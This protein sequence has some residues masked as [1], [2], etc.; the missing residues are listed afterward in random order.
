MK[1]LW[2]GIGIIVIAV[3]TIV[4][5]TYTRKES[6]VIKIGVILP[7]TGP[8]GQYGQWIKDALEIARDEINSE[9]G[10][11]DKILSIIYQEIFAR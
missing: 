11:N 4:I 3:I 1:K 6:N 7:L 5:I 10:I 9:T 2:I 8:S